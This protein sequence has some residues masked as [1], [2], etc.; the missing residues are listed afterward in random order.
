MRQII[1][2]LILF[3]YIQYSRVHPLSPCHLPKN[4]DDFFSQVISRKMPLESFTGECYYLVEVIA[5]VLC[6]IKDQLKK[7]LRLDS[8]PDFEWVITVPAIWE[9]KGKQMMREAAYKVRRLWS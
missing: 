1:S 3:A 8:L 2:A 7:H 9:A 4:H 5:F 6:H